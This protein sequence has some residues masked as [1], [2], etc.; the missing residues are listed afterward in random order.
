MIFFQVNPSRSSNEDLC[1]RYST[2]FSIKKE[3]IV[4]VHIYRRCASTRRVSIRSPFL[5][6]FI[7]YANSS[8]NAPVLT[9]SLSVARLPRVSASTHEQPRCGSMPSPRSRHFMPGSTPELRQLAT[10][11]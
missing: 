10:P 5:S 11:P 4:F 8:K 6:V 7:G 9:R 2:C 1:S 3:R